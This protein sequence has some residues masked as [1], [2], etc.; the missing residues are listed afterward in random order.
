MTERN[1]ETVIRTWLKRERLWWVRHCDDYHKFFYGKLHL[2][3][4][5]FITVILF[6]FV[7]ENNNISVVQFSD[8]DWMSELISFA[9]SLQIQ[10][11]TLCET[12]F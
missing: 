8:N 12:W 6:F 3:P 11:H 5:S 2:K 7:T 4:H 1:Y 9:A 10:L